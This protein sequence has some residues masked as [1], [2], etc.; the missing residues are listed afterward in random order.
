MGFPRLLLTTGLIDREPRSRRQG[1][2]D[3]GSRQ[4]IE[5]DRI[6]VESGVYHGVT[7]G[8]PITLRL[9]NNDAK[10]ERLSEPAAH[11]RGPH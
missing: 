6:I 1:A 4:Q 8:S 5:T 9:I 7:T 2:M 10:L 3:A 11:A